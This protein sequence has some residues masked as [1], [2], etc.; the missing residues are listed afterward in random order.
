M[1]SFSAKLKQANLVNK[2]DFYDKT[3]NLSQKITSIKTK[4]VLVENELK[5]YKYLTQVFL[6]VKVTLIMMK[7]NFTHYFNQS[8]KLLIH[9]LVSQT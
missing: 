6:L 7:H 5:N 9:F 2:T 8:T 3:K 4:H 1:E